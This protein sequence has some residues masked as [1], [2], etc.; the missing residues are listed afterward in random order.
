MSSS[1]TVKRHN[2][3]FTLPRTS[4]NLLTQ[5]LNLPAQ[6]GIHRVPSDGYIFL[7]SLIHRFMHKL[8]GKN[9]TEWTDEERSGMKE[10]FQK[11]YNDLGKWSKEAEEGG[12][13]IFIKEHIN[14]L[15]S[16]VDET[17][18]LFS[19]PSTT[20]PELFTVL[21]ADSAS[22]PIARSP[23]NETCFP[24][25]VLS[26]LFPTILIRNPILTLPSLLRT[27]IDIEG[28]ETALATPIEVWKWECSYHWSRTLY[29]FYH[30]LPSSI[31]SGVP[32]IDY[33][34]ILDADDLPNQELMGRYATAVGLDPSFIRFSWPAAPKSEVEATGK[35]IA[36]MKDTLLASSGIVEGKSS[37]G[38]SIEGER[39]KWEKE[40]GEVLAGRVVELWEELKGDYE[41]LFERRFR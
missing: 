29:D 27:S 35:N 26:S 21:P 9:V 13:G 40:F 17:K 24:D 1:S 14:W 15:L 37:Q 19:V 2:F 33:P 38:L 31:P 34:I 36:R 12:K 20:F 6:P 18:F 23:Y 3:I 22:S 11:A 7:P 30:S 10:A 4:S 39:L 8:A 25:S 28:L 5:I 16:P 41:W 32:E